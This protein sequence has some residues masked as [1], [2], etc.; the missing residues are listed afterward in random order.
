MGERINSI[1][2]S[3]SIMD[4]SLTIETF[5]IYIDSIC[6]CYTLTC[7]RGFQH[8]PGGVYGLPIQLLPYGWSVTC[9]YVTKDTFQDPKLIG[10]V[11]KF[12]VVV[13]LRSPNSANS[14][15]VQRVTHPIVI[16]YIAKSPH[17]S[18]IQYYS[19]WWLVAR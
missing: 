17:P 1:T 6:S 14:N 19:V 8:L 9:S 10:F 13:M 15:M 4:G 5:L 18:D 3:R 7:H 2:G 12:I 11:L 16:L